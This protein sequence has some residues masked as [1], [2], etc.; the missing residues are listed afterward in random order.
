MYIII[1]LAII[2]MA[3]AVDRYLLKS[4]LKTADANVAVLKASIQ[5]QNTAYQKLKT[6]SDNLAAQLRNSEK[7]AG[8][9]ERQSKAMA[10]QIMQANAGTSCDEAIQFGIDEAEKIKDEK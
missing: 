6:E 3:L 7:K 8:I 1:G 10:A 2:L 5:I 4:E 9:I